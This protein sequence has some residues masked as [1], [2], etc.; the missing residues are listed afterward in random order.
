MVREVLLVP[1]MV[2]VVAALGVPVIWAKEI[3]L[4]P[5]METLGLTLYASSKDLLVCVA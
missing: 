4:I 2:I 5:E 1:V 3:S